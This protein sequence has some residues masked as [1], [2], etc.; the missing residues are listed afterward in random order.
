MRKMSKDYF[1]IV[2]T[3]VD[4]ILLVR[5]F[6]NEEL[7][8]KYDQ[9]VEQVGKA[10]VSIHLHTYVKAIVT[11][12]L[13]DASAIFKELEKTV[14]DPQGNKVPVYSPQSCKMILWEIYESITD[15]YEL[16]KLD[17]ICSDINGSLIGEVVLP[18][19]DEDLNKGLVDVVDDYREVLA[20]YD[21]LHENNNEKHEIPIKSI[22]R[23]EKFLKSR[24]IGQDSAIDAV[25]KILKLIYAGFLSK[26]V[27]LFL[28]PTG[29]GKTYLSKLLAKRYSQGRIWRIDCG[30]YGNAHEYSKL[31]GSPPG[32]IGHNDES[33]AKRKADESSKWVILIDEI[34][35]A[36]YKFQ[37]FL[38]KWLDEGVLTDNQGEELNFTNSIFILTSNAG[39]QDLKV[40]T[41]VGFGLDDSY[42]NKKELLKESVKKHFNPEF[43][44]RI[45]YLQVFDTLSKEAIRQIAK[46]ELNIVPVKKNKLL[47]DHLT[48]EGFSVE[49]GAR[50]LKR[51]ILDN[52]AIL[53]ADELLNNR[54]PKKGEK[55]YTV[56][57]KN[58]KLKVV[59][60]EELKR[61]EKDGR[62]H[63]NE[64]SD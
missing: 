42:T 30:E 5:R 31:I 34:E 4:K 37:D 21:L 53:I 17:S 47:L 24:V 59:N 57:V 14:T 15:L 64:A 45:D 3:T 40:G 54:V 20:K 61:E 9:M 28:G 10:E 55:L 7:Q 18:E 29:V 44:N 51:Y 11:F 41:T 16:F 50:H 36:H 26:G 35:K 52:I 8:V 39:V 33:P 63:G 32:Y 48:K 2:C 60:T 58:G 62:I 13:K 6:T 12:F 22:D 38:L 49:Y 1:K 25:T 56:R 43:L 23:I 46:L 27:L 19:R